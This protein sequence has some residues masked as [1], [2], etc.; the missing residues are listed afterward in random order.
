[1]VGGFAGNFVS[2]YEM[3]ERKGRKENKE[4]WVEVRMKKIL[5]YIRRES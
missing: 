1:M 5:I 4:Q 2:F 3:K